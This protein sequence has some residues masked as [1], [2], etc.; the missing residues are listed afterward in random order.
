V[1]GGLRSRGDEAQIDEDLGGL[2][3][4]HPDLAGIMVV[5]VLSLIGL[6]PLV[7]FLGKIYLIG[8]AYSAGFP[9]SIAL[10]IIMVLNS[11]IS[12]AY[13]LRIANACFFG[14]PAQGV[15]LAPGS[16]RR[17]GAGVAALLAIAMGFGIGSSRLIEGANDYTTITPREDAAVGSPDTEKPDD[18]LAL[19]E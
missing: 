13:Y 4:R 9:G 18:D 7:G 12:A 19:R 5:S 15:T 14:K 10:I 11:A 16:A 8:P 17:V 6:P 1:L 3:K 2:V